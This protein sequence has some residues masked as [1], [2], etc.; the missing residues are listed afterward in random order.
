V[1]VSSFFKKRFL[2]VFLE[3]PLFESFMITKRISADSLDYYRN[4]EK[5]DENRSQ[6][7][8]IYSEWHLTDNPVVLIKGFILLP[9]HRNILCSLK[10]VRR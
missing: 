9:I 8:K 5:F 4:M 2:K 1:F 6:N 10:T 7:S 3:T